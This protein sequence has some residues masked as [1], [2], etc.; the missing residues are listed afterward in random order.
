MKITEPSTPNNTHFETLKNGLNSYNET[1]TGPKK[2]E[3][4][5]SFLEDEDN[6][7]FG[8]ILSEINWDWMH[9]KGLW[10]DSDKRKYGWVG[11]KTF[12]KNGRICYL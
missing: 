7:I 9:I 8:G 11:F 5:S 1:F 6:S 10:I 12:S 2:T 3:T 4:V